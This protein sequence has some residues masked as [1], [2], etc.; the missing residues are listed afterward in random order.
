MFGFGTN[1]REVDDPQATVFRNVMQAYGQQAIENVGFVT[2]SFGDILTIAKWA[3][4]IGYAH[5]SPKAF[6]QQISQWTGPGFMLPGQFHCGANKTLIGV[7]GNAASGSTFAGGKWVS[8]GSY[9]LS[10][11]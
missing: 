10:S 8:V 4:S 9:A 6:E 3:N 2:K 1:P 7:C 5:L 11:Y